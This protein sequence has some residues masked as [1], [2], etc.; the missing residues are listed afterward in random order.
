MTERELGINLIKQGFNFYPE[1]N[2]LVI[3]RP[4]AGILAKVGIGGELS[5][6]YS[7]NTPRDL[8]DLIGHYLHE[9]EV[10]HG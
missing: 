4:E 7:A 9:N 3:F 6:S 1:G 5:V 2:K 8:V 10:Q